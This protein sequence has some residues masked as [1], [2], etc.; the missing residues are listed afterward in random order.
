MRSGCSALDVNGNL[1]GASPHTPGI[2]RFG[3]D[4]GG[5]KRSEAHTKRAS[6]SDLGHWSALGSRPRVALSSDQSE[7]TVAQE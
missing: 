5:Q 7:K 1:V 6:L 4:L 3:A 2:Y